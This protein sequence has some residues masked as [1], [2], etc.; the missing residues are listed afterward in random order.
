V[1]TYYN[2]DGTIASKELRHPDEV[3]KADSLATLAS[4]PVTV[5]HPK[6][7]K[8]DTDNYRAVTVGTVD[9]PGRKSSDGVHVDSDVR[10]QDKGV[11]Q[12]VESKHLVEISAGYHCKTDKQDGV[13]DGPNGPESYTHVQREIR[14]NHIAL[15]PA[16]EG[17][18]GSSVRLRLDASGEAL[19]DEADPIAKIDGT[20]TV[21]PMLTPEQI[22]A[23]QADRDA[24][25]LKVDALEPQVR[26]LDALNGQVAY[27]KGEN[28]RLT[29]ELTAAKAA[30]PDQTKVDSLVDARVSLVTEARLVLDAK[31][32]PYKYQGKTD[33]QVRM[34]VLAKLAPHFKCD[35]KTP[36]GH[37]AG[38]YE[39]AVSAYRT[40]AQ[41]LAA[42]Q[43]ATPAARAGEARTDQKDTIAEARAKAVE[44]SNNAWKLP[45][46]IQ[47]AQAK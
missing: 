8:V 47:M 2:V 29:T 40:G 19:T 20:L 16:N 35:N 3:F 1:F 34:D 4:A 38:A 43:G 32:A 45:R 11:I 33:T 5:R 14:Y 23:L 9:G 28:T 22:T 18:A 46:S 36:E 6:E 37:V 15:L 21:S 25:K 44:A 41:G 12:A 39:M 13:Y 10:V 26:G 42:I 27:L 31:D 17:R 24:L 7:R 30:G